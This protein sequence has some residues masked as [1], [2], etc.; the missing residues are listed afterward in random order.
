M[1]LDLFHGLSWRFLEVLAPYNLCPMQDMRLMAHLTLT[2]HFHFCS[3]C[4]AQFSTILVLI[5]FFLVL[6]RCLPQY[7]FNISHTVIKLFP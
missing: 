3:Q 4:N 5:R 7:S 1:D 2:A 6:L